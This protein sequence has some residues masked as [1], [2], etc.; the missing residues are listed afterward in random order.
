MPY[1][2]ARREDHPGALTKQSL[3]DRKRE[4][5]DER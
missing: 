5:W 1:E 2:H 4:D 3:A